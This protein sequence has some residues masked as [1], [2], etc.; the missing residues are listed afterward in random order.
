MS[1]EMKLG[2]E[3]PAAPMNELPPQSITEVSSDPETI[4]VSVEEKSNDDDPM[5]Y[6][7]KLAAEG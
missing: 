5:S 6:F 7:A 1:D 3:T 2:N 4:T